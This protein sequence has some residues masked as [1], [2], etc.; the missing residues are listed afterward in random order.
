MACVAVPRAPYAL[1]PADDDALPVAPYDDDDDAAQEAEGVVERNGWV[2]LRADAG[3][4]EEVE[5][6][7]ELRARVGADEKAKPMPK[8]KARAG[9]QRKRSPWPARKS[10]LAWQAKGA[11]SMRWNGPVLTV[12]GLK[13]TVRH[14]DT[15]V[16]TTAKMREQSRRAMRHQKPITS[17]AWNAEGKLLASGDD[18][19]LILCWDDRMQLPLDVGEH[20]GRRKKMTHAG[21]ITVSPPGVCVCVVRC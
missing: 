12:G 1:H 15:R 18:S 19:G 9:P 6:A 5:E 2:A 11:L 16:A 13:G 21:A 17:L 4:D 7:L 14:Y 10:T 8:E 3:S 20:N